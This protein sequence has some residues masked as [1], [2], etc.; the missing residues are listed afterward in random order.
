[1]YYVKGRNLPREAMASISR[2]LFY[3]QSISLFDWEAR[4]QSHRPPST[5]SNKGTK[6]DSTKLK[7]SLLGAVNDR[8][9]PWMPIISICTK[10]LDAPS[11]ISLL[12]RIDHRSSSA[13]RTKLIATWLNLMLC[14]LVIDRALYYFRHYH[15]DRILVK[16]TVFAALACDMLTIIA[17]CADVYLK[18]FVDINRNGGGP[19]NRP[20]LGLI[21]SS[22]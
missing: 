15:T 7:P 2:S 21:L 16:I 1:M 17:E 10:S 5:G 22:H 3:L 4:A 11:F 20:T 14:V 8:F 12:M 13:N 19:I 6:L 9:K 18:M